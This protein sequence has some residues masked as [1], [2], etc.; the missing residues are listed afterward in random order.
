MTMPKTSARQKPRTLGADGIYQCLAEVTI[1]NKRGLH[2]RAS[3][4]FVKAAEK[5]D[6][7]VTVLKDDQKVCGSS[8]MGLMMLG[9][10]P[11]TILS[12]ETEGPEAEE[13]LEALTA[14]IE[15][16]FHETD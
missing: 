14:L 5:F 16:G 11:G 1:V 12:I 13:A 9:A 15:A 6:A 2:A 8:I 4:A 7:E 10:G 3:A